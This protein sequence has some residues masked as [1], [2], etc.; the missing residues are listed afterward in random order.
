M[1]LVIGILGM[2]FNG[3]RSTVFDG[4]RSVCHLTA[5]YRNPWDSA[6]SG[7]QLQPE[8]AWDENS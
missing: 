2:V 5:E 8:R 3:Y 4:Y 1:T 6:A 7:R